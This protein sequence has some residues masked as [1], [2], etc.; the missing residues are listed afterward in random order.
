MYSDSST[1]YNEIFSQMG[2]SS[3]IGIQSNKKITS[4]YKNIE[5][6]NFT[7]KN[8]KTN[9]SARE[10]Q[11][12][13]LLNKYDTKEQE[14][15]KI[16]NKFDTNFEVEN[17]ELR[18][19]EMNIKLNDIEKILK[20]E[21]NLKNND[22]SYLSNYL[23]YITLE[24][25]KNINEELKK[26][27][28]FNETIENKK[29]NESN[30]NNSSFDINDIKI[31]LDRKTILINFFKKYRNI[32]LLK[33]EFK[34]IRNKTKENLII[35]LNKLI[36]M[37]NKSGNISKIDF[38]KL[39]EVIKKTNTS[40]VEQIKILKYI[41]EFVDSFV[42]NPDNRNINV[43]LLNNHN[44]HENFDKDKKFAKNILVNEFKIEINRPDMNFD[45]A[46]NFFAGTDDLEFAVSNYFQNKYQDE[47]LKM[48]F[49]F[50]SGKE[51][52]LIKNFTDTP[53][54]IF[55]DITNIIVF[56]E[57]KEIIEFTLI[58]E[59]IGRIDIVNNMKYIGGLNILKNKKIYVKY[60]D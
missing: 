22:V 37:G 4:I 44:N 38:D 11:V 30:P 29:S 59:G 54:S 1:K 24:E 21:T 23:E 33:F 42:V 7:F 28:I 32:F 27:I 60:L 8:L 51:Y 17:L 40:S 9:N 53:S 25:Y 57:K 16:I 43:N 35:Y 13:N 47:N 3:S 34:N 41:D 39:N 52:F 14:I 49:L 6:L 18:K 2:F 26:I 20:H 15:T 55:D 46:E 48:V 50:P 19:K 36:G 56:E 58:Q 45:T 10:K 31:S 5:K 12:G